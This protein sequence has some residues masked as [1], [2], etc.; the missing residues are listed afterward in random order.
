MA[1]KILFL[2]SSPRKKGNTNTVAGWCAQSATDAGGKVECIDIAKL[3]Y[4][5]NGCIS[6]YSCQGSDK[7][8]CAVKDDANAILE[9]MSDFDV[10][11]CSTPVYMFGPCAQL[12]LLFDRTYSLMKFDA[13]TGDVILQSPGQVMALIAT[14]GGGIDDG[15]NLTDQTFKSM[16]DFL[17]SKYLSL[18]VPEAPSDPKQLEENSE[19]KQKA[20]EFGRALVE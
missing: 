11:V 18:L 13:D 6:C 20:I 19:L 7:Y 15:L 14:A 9:R 10:V 2:N 1:K 16:A 3:N 5:S 4:K 8:E 12:K 17:S